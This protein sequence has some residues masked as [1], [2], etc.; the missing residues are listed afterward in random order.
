MPLVYYTQLGQDSRCILFLK[1]AGPSMKS[2]TL[3]AILLL[4][5]SCLAGCAGDDAEEEDPVVE[6]PVGDAIQQD[7]ETEQQPTANESAPDSEEG[8]VVYDQDGDGVNDTSD[9]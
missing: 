7:S 2:K 5:S 1:H 9:G 4:I 8:E 6:D 3:I